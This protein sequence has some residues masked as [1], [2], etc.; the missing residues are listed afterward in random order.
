MAADSQH[1]LASAH[2]GGDPAE[3]RGAADARKKWRLARLAVDADERDFL[4]A[5]D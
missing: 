3:N 1:R 2:A 5:G 4:L